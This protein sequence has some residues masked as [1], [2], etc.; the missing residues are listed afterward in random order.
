M[1]TTV[2]EY[3]HARLLA[4]AIELPYRSG[5]PEA[6]GEED[7]W[8]IYRGRGFGLVG[9]PAASDHGW[10]VAFARDPERGEG[11]VIAHEATDTPGFG[12]ALCLSSRITTDEA[13]AL[14]QLARWTGWWR[15]PAVEAVDVE[16]LA[17]WL[18]TAVPVLR[19]AGEAAV[20]RHLLAELL[21]RPANSDVTPPA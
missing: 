20:Q 18:A 10:L 7:D 14:L 13:D 6:V 15:P 2:T 4:A 17:E 19:K 9:G 1:T 3:A 12:R 11:H 21:E 5:I 16:A 8:G